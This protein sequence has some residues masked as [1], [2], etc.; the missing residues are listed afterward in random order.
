MAIRRMALF[1]ALITI[2]LTAISVQAGT[3]ITWTAIGGPTGGLVTAL[4]S[5]GDASDPLLAGTNG[6]VYLSRDAG[7]H[8]QSSSTGLLDDLAI[9]ALAVSHDAALT[10]AGIRSRIYR[11]RGSLS[12]H[13]AQWML[14]DPHLATQYVLSL[15][16]DS[17][18]SSLIYAGTE[19][20]LFKS[21]N[22]GEMADQ[23]RFQSL[24]VTPT[25]LEGAFDGLVLYSILQRDGPKYAFA[26]NAFPQVLRRSQDVNELRDTLLREMQISQGAKAA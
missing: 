23:T 11:T 24:Q 2:A 26:T 15:L 10:F 22:G 19:T 17:Q 7:A 6:G 8:W 5:A 9:T 21:E 13:D 1:L 14:A 25:E 18:N 3:N 4:V 16:I 20:S 12:T